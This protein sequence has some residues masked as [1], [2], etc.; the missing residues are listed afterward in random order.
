MAQFDNIV[1][2]LKLSI[3]LPVSLAHGERAFSCLKHVKT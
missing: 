3:T 1:T 2:L